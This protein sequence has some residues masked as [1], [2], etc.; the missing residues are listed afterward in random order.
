MNCLP[1]SFLLFL[2]ASCAAPTTPAPIAHQP[3]TIVHSEADAADILSPQTLIGLWDD[4]R[5]MEQIFLEFQPDGTGQVITMAPAPFEWRLDPKSRS[6]Y[7]TVH[8]HDFPAE[9]YVLIATPHA[10]ELRTTSFYGPN[11]EHA[12]VRVPA[13]EGADK[14]LAP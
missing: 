7:L 2:I 5:V 8:P 4:H 12:F 10:A 1:I 6:I 3:P 11:T 13:S 9:H 14:S